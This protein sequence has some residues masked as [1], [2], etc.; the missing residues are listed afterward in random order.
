MF[1]RHLLSCTTALT[2]VLAIAAPTQAADVPY[3]RGSWTKEIGDVQG[4]VNEGAALIRRFGWRCDSVS[5]IVRRW[6]SSGFVFYCNDFRYSYDVWD[7]GGRWVA[8]I[9]D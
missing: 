6:P 1:C 2:L 7:R 9:N 5:S 8:K 3:T 4:V